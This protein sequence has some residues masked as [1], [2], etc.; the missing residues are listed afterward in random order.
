MKSPL[1]RN[2]VSRSRCVSVSAFMSSSSKI[3][4][5]GR[6]LI[7]VPVAS[8]V[9]DEL[10]GAERVAALE[11]LT[12]ELP[13][14]PD[15]GD[16]PLGERVHDRCADAVEAAGDLVAVASEFAAGVKLREDR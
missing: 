5:S 2:A 1:V 7:V 15:L 14:A 10:H 4:E 12:V 16:E 8:S 11:L 6:K 13:V 9:A 3:S